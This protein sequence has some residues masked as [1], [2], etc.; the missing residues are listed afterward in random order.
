MSTLSVLF[1][2]TAA[3][4]SLLTPLAAFSLLVFCLLYTPCLAA[5]AAVRRELGGRWAIG[6]VAFQCTVAWLVSLLIFHAG[7]WLG[8]S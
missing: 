1:G 2:S 6:M 7:R 3:L 8:F 5:I 4:H